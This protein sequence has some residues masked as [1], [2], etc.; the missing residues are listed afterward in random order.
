MFCQDNFLPNV[1]RCMKE[2]YRVLKNNGKMISITHG[3]EKNRKFF[4]RNRFSPFQV[5]V[6]PLP[7]KSNQ[8]LTL[9][10]V[11]TKSSDE[12]GEVREED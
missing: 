6:I 5:E 12:N 1:F 7:K 3:K 11:L 8:P 4:Y 9:I 10:F 2:C